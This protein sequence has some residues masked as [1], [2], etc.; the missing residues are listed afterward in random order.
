MHA[1][2]VGV[3][4]VGILLLLLF[5]R[6]RLGLALALV[7][8]IGFSYLVTPEAGLSLFGRK[9]F[10]TMATYG[11]TVVPLFILM[12]QFTFYSGAGERL[13]ETAYKL[14]GR[15]PGGLAIS[16]IV[17]CAIFAAICGSGPATAATI[18][19]VSL[20]EMK[21]YKY[22]LSLASGSIAAGGTLGI[23]IPPSVG[24][25][26]YGIIA[27]QSIGK[28][29]IAAVIPG[30]LLSCLFILNIYFRVK[31]N[32][33]LAPVPPR[34]YSYKEKLYSFIGIWETLLLFLFVLGGL[35]GGI[36]TPTEAGAIGACGSFLISTFQK[37]MNLS[38]FIKAVRD[39]VTLTGMIFTILIGAMI[40]SSFLAITKLPDV[41]SLI[42]MKVPP[43]L[44]MGWIFLIC[45]LAG[46]ILDAP[47]MI[48]LLVPIFLPTVTRIGFDAVW[49]GVIIVIL[50]EAGLISP[51][52]GLNVFT[53]AGLDK[54]IPIGVV[55][56]GVMPFILMII[57]TLIVLLIC[58]DIVLFLPDYMG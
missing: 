29:F 8:A 51:P 52:V 4:G 55:F 16:N 6:M 5:L 13:Y 53:I 22:D 40:F 3:V 19:S 42:S 38:E 12:G 36:F 9:P 10:E 26:V 14:V 47:S 33:A 54:T 1:A 32:A 11:L 28:L 43:F 24:L 49:F 30:I 17:G 25:I 44:A 58:P 15:I 18:G 56:K 45:L 20:P 39:T 27:E 31:V 37:K 48:V 46:C 2:I 34:Q 41:V 35:F 7:G 57:L 23:L 50:G 21:K